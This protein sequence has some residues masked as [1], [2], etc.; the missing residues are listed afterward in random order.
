MINKMGWQIRPHEYQNYKYE[1][2]YKYPKF[3]FEL[4]FQV[5]K[6]EYRVLHLSTT[7]DCSDSSGV[8]LAVPRTTNCCTITFKLQKLKCFRKYLK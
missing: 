4:Y 2:D 7:D 3:S 5:Y 6:S 8:M 1:R